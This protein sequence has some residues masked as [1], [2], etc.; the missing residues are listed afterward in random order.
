MPIHEMS[1]AENIFFTRQVGYIDHIDVS[2]WADTLATHAQ[3]SDVPIMAVVTMLEVDRLCPTIIDVCARVLKM[4]N[5]LGIGVVTGNSMTPRD[6]RILGQL[7]TLPGVHLFPTLDR[8]LRF[9]RS[10]SQ[11]SITP[12]S[13][14][15]MMR[16]VTSHRI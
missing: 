3:Q 16:L 8:A 5:V 12:L 11:P 10:Q 1:F 9:A 14:S 13:N 15:S 2:T 7:K 4:T 6:S